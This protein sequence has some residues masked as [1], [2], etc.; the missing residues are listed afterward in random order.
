MLDRNALLRREPHLNPVG[1]KGGGLYHEAFTDDARLVLDTLE[2]ACRAGALL[3]NHRE[4]IRLFSE[5]GLVAGAEVIDRISGEQTLIRTR[6]VINAT[7]PWVDRVLSLQQPVEHPTL[8]PTKGVHIVLRTEDFP[9]HTPVAL[10]SPSDGRTVFL[11]PTGDS[12]H[13]YIGTTDTDFIGSVDNV[14]GDKQDFEYLLGVANHTLRDVKVKLKDIVASWAALRPIVAPAL[15]TPNSNASR[16]HTVATGPGGVITVAGGKLTTARLM[17]RQVIDV[18]VAQL[19]ERH[20]IRGVPASTTGTVP[21]SGGDPG[22]LMRAEREVP[23]AD[24]AEKTRRR[25]LRRYGGNA[26]ILAEQTCSEPEKGQRVGGTDLTPAEITY[27]VEHQMAMTVSDVLVRRT[28]SFFWSLDGDAAAVGVVSDALD[29]AYGYP[30]ERRKAQQVDYAT[31]VARN[32]P[33]PE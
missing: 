17:A 33:L 9:L 21:V 6:A 29:A 16:G 13:V 5:S 1:L 28:G 23:A 3:S 15:G 10:R 19:R 20:G 4:V 22:E 30:L 18:A 31:W 32:R 12:K 25:W 14:V 8:R 24:V 2:S 7:G 11:A 27:A 26:A